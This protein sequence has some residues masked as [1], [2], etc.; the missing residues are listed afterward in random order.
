MQGRLVGFEACLRSIL[1][2]DTTT[3]LAKQDAHDIL[4]KLQ[5]LKRSMNTRIE[6]GQYYEGTKPENEYKGKSPASNSS[7]NGFRPLRT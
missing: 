1:G 3:V 7:G 5:S 2:E 6:C 4:D